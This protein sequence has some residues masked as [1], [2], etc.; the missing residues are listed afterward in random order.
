MPVKAVRG[1][2]LPSVMGLLCV[3]MRGVEGCGLEEV[4]VRGEGGTWKGVRRLSHNVYSNMHSDIS[5]ICA[6]GT[7][8]SVPIS[9]IGLKMA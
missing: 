3:W 9:E 6:H 2:L 5:L 1:V 8:E 4:D 7:G